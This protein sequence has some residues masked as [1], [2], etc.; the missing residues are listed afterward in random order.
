MRQNGQLNI[1]L[2]SKIGINCTECADNNRKLILIVSDILRPNQG[3]LN[4]WLR[5]TFWYLL[6]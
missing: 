3:R 2:N 6:Q 5:K 4:I 1:W